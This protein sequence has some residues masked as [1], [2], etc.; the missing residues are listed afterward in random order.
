MLSAALLTL[1]LLAASEDEASAPRTIQLQPVRLERLP[2][3]PRR[4]LRPARALADGLEVAGTRYAVSLEDGAPRIATEPDASPTKR[5]RNGSVLAVKPWESAKTAP[6]ELLFERRADQWTWGAASARK[7]DLDGLELCLVDVDAD[8]TLDLLH[9]GWSLGVGGPLLPLANVLLLDDRELHI[10]RLARDGSELVGKVVA[11]PG[12]PAQRAA[13]A[14]LNRLRLGEGLSAVRLEPTLSAGCSLH[15]E[16]LA[17]R[18]WAGGAG[19]HEQD[20]GAED[21]T[22]AGLVAA[23]KSEVLALAPAAALDELWRGLAGRLLL[24]DPDLVA[25]GVSASEASLAVIDLRSRSTHR[26]G[27]AVAYR[28]VRLSPASG[29]LGRPTHHAADPDATPVEKASKAG[30]PLLIEL[31]RGA[32]GLEDYEFELF[33]DSGSRQRLTTI[34]LP[35]ADERPGVL[36]ALPKRPLEAGRRYLAIHRLTLDGEE[37]VF[38]ARFTTEEKE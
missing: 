19:A 16:Y 2:S 23:R 30:P 35:R 31:A 14:R 1:T 38:E 37:L 21:A 11:L 15:A 7:L 9:D 27:A 34:P 33:V 10:E 26:E 6:V 8:G 25:V 4:T 24:A 18:G 32:A 3:S 36:G 17:R 29:S 28:D 13:L 20:P 12:A 5:I 22:R